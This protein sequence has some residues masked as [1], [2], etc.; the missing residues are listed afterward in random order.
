MKVNIFAYEAYLKQ[1]LLNYLREHTAKSI[2]H[3]PEYAE[4]LNDKE[5]IQKFLT[6]ENN[7]EKVKM[8]QEAYGGMKP[9]E[10]TEEELQKLLTITTEELKQFLYE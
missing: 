7:E 9:F 4:K 8:I 2:E 1:K 3:N 10:F 5:F 6:T